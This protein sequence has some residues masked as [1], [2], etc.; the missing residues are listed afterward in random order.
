MEET[1]KTKDKDENY[2]I[3]SIKNY[4]IDIDD[5]KLIEKAIKVDI[6][7]ENY[8]ENRKFVENINL[9]YEVF[10]YSKNVEG[11]INLLEVIYKF[12]GI[13]NSDITILSIKIGKK[14]YTN[15]HVYVPVSRET[16]NKIREDLKHII[17]EIR[18]KKKGKVTDFSENNLQINENNLVRNDRLAGKL[19]V[20][21]YIKK[22][23]LGDLVF[24]YLD[25]RL[26]RAR[27]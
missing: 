6:Y 2:I 5:L 23:K 11:T 20:P 26:A 25:Y 27:E 18:T 13:F 22:K 4:I 7:N 15:V 16:V 14:F 9:V 24:Y 10:R 17:H 19:I 1:K 8:I 3:D 12:E 21:L